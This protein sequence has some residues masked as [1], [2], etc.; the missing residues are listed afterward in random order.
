MFLLGPPNFIRFRATAIRSR[1]SSYVGLPETSQWWAFRMERSPTSSIIISGARYLGEVLARLRHRSKIVPYRPH[2]RLFGRHRH[3]RARFQIRR[4]FGL[5]REVG[6][7]VRPSF[8]FVM[9]GSGSCGFNLS[10]FD[11]LPCTLASLRSSLANC[12]RVGAAI[13]DFGASCV[14]NS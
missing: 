8:T 3:R 12:S 1:V 14:R 7:S 11:P 10:S 2:L 9:R 13:P 6:S 5:V 4:M